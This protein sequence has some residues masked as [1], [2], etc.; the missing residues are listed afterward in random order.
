[1]ERTPEGAT[2]EL[3][4][5]GGP[6]PRYRG[7]EEDLQDDVHQHLNSPLQIATRAVENEANRIQA[8]IQILED[9]KRKAEDDAERAQQNADAKADEIE[10]AKVELEMHTLETDQLMAALR[11]IEVAESAVGSSVHF[12]ETQYPTGTAPKYRTKVWAAVIAVMKDLE[13]NNPHVTGDILR[14]DNG[15]PENFISKKASSIYWIASANTMQKTSNMDDFETEFKNKL[16]ARL[17]VADQQS[18]Q[19]VATTPMINVC[20]NR[21]NVP[22]YFVHEFNLSEE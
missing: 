5:F 17:N 12:Y 15:F 19:I 11:K 9:E 13:F 8:K 22:Q 10:I 7:N 6:V 1:M 3:N 16:L 4:R 21:N 18:I 20:I 14:R 2:P